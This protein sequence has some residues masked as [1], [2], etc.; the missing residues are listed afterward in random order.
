MINKIEQYTKLKNVFR[1]S[2]T[3]TIKPY[4]VFE[5]SF[6]VLVLFK[7]IAD[8]NNVEYTIETLDIVMNHD[9]VE[10]ITGD[11]VYTV[12]KF[13]E[14]TSLS[15]SEIEKELTK[16]TE[17]EKYSDENIKNK[18]ND[19]QYSLLKCCDT[20]DLY[21][22]LHEEWCSGNRRREILNMATKC[23]EIIWSLPHRFTQSA[24]IIGRRQF[25]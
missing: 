8:Q 18:L 4:N 11:L 22:Y 13:N 2:T 21:M 5:H 9:I 23:K 19:E 17:Y 20:L 25:V 12:K 16:N 1:M 14:K 15:W 6:G 10:S 3:N 7:I 24:E